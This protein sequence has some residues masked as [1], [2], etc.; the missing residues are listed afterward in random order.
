MNGSKY[1]VLRIFHI[2]VII[3]VRQK[4]DSSDGR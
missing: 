4:E 2:V 3:D 1:D